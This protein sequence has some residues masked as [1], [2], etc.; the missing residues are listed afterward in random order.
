[1]THSLHFTS[2]P[3]CNM[4]HSQVVARSKIGRRLLFA[5]VVPYPTPP[6][7]LS[8]RSELENYDRG[9]SEANQATDGVGRTLAAVRLE[10]LAWRWAEGCKPLCQSG[11]TFAMQL[12]VGKVCGVRKIFE[13]R[14]KEG[15]R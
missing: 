5:A 15:G 7:L 4:P 9:D 12:I 8:Y 10:R 3:V 1:M 13:M 6:T 11:P 2:Q 14:D